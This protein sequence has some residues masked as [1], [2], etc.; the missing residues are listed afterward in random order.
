[1]N[2]SPPLLFPRNINICWGLVIIGYT[3]R[4]RPRVCVQL[5]TCLWLSVHVLVATFHQTRPECDGAAQKSRVF[6]QQPVRLWWNTPGRWLSMG[7]KNKMGL[8]SVLRKEWTFR[9]ME[10]FLILTTPK[11]LWLLEWENVII[12]LRLE[13]NKYSKHTFIRFCV[14]P[15]TINNCTRCR[16]D[17]SDIFTYYIL[18]VI[19]CFRGPSLQPRRVPPRHGAGEGGGELDPLLIRHPVIFSS[20]PPTEI[21]T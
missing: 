2:S 16:V 11:V 10:M 8:I 5:Y 17:I 4:V 1:M 15:Y 13:T 9:S 6:W 14:A 18:I 21:I 12:H 3:A 20:S 19:I 7:S